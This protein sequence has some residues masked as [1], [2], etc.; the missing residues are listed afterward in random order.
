M[1]GGGGGLSTK[2]LA[3][4]TSNSVKKKLFLKPLAIHLALIWAKSNISKSGQEISEYIVQPF[5]VSPVTDS[6]PIF[7]FD[8]DPDPVRLPI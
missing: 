2:A 3:T 8:T 5:D 6:N 1:G 7:H 4:V